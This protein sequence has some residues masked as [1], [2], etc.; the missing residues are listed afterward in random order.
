MER[1]LLINNINITT[2]NV[3]IK[4]LTAGLDTGPFDLY[5]DVDNFVTAFETGISRDSLVAGYTSTEVPAGT[6]EIKIHSTGSC[7]NSIIVPVTISVTTTST[8]TIYVPPTTT[9]TTTAD[10]L[11]TTTTTT[12]HQVEYY[13][14][15]SCFTEDQE[16]CE[17]SSTGYHVGD[18]I[19]FTKP[20]DLR[21]Y[22]GTVTD[23]HYTTG[24]ATVF[25]SSPPPTDCNDNCYGTW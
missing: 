10:P 24:P 21:S 3:Y 9:T 16:V 15:T 14:I 22:C 11:A 19:R 23:I 8:T 12:T 6:T 5:S 17:K 7:T 20:N 2:M 13:L 25:L 4:L 18:F 1:F